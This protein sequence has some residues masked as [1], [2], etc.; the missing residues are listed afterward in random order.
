MNKRIFISYR[1]SDS[2][3]TTRALAERLKATFGIESIFLDESTIDPGQQWPTTIRKA[4]SGATVV[5]VVIGPS[6][7][8][9][10]DENGQRRL[11]N[12]SDWVRCEIQTALKDQ[13]TI[14][15]ILIKNTNIPPSEEIPEP[16]RA[17][18]NY[19]CY[20]LYDNVWEGQLENLITILESTYGFVRSAISNTPSPQ[21]IPRSDVKFVGREKEIG[22]LDKQ[23]MRNNQELVAITG[24]GGLGKTELAIQYALKYYE[25][26]IYLGGVCW[27][28]ATRA[29]DL[30]QQMIDFAKTKMNLDVPEEYKTEK[31]EQTEEKKLETDKIFAQWFWQ[32]FRLQQNPL[33][34]V[35]LDD[36]TN[37][38][39]VKN[40]LPPVSS[41]FKVL[42]TTRLNFKGYIPELPLEVLQEDAAVNLLRQW[43][44][45]DKID[46]QTE[47]AKR[48]CNYLGKLPLALNLVAKYVRDQ[49]I[50]LEKML[51]QLQNKQS[52]LT[53]EALGVDTNDPTMTLDIDRGVA[54]AFELSWE[55][56]TD[57]AKQLA[58]LLSLL[59]FTLYEWRFVEEKISALTSVPWQ[60]VQAQ[61]NEVRKARNQLE[62]L[63]LLQGENRYQLHSLIRE[64][65]RLK[66]VK[67][68]RG[69]QVKGIIGMV[70]LDPNKAI[71]P[72]N[73]SR[74]PTV[75]DFVGYPGC[76]VACYSHTKEGSQYSVGGN[77]YVMGQI[78]VEG[79]YEGRICKPKGYETADI[80]AEPKFKELC[81]EKLPEVCQDDSCW[82]GGDTG[83]F[84]GL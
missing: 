3:D 36:V 33:V 66:L 67:Y 30:K 20:F 49:N 46:S 71:L 6:W 10:S 59:P 43:I 22:E 57:I 29:S 31:S 4:L 75:N 44:D 72:A 64:F 35:I 38:P 58:I 23:L 11:D 8:R 39:Q 82:A 60:L 28:K 7:L 56:L 54:A 55:L 45:D 50:T 32:R 73:F 24:M 47:Q 70:D 51:I 76:Y 79:R 37:Y 15:P 2:L 19:Q 41:H 65:F 16:L 48:L 26:K 78:R 69:D 34:L 13:K 53:D 83:G 80:S 42:M 25:E 52:I 17:F 74:L 77:I 61:S 63:N 62:Q 1:R 27:L 12:E 40:Y 81:A 21:N 84:L 9:A 5:L 18:L 68:E 14:I